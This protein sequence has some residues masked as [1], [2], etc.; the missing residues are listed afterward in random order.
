MA[1]VPADERG[2][3]TFDQGS[4]PSR[5]REVIVVG[6]RIYYPHPGEPPYRDT[7]EGLPSIQFPGMHLQYLLLPKQYFV[8]GKS[9]AN[10]EN[11][12]R[13][14]FSGIRSGTL[15]SL[16]LPSLHRKIGVRASAP[17]IQS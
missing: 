8:D 5:P 16:L 10:R 14:Y 11:A 2:I 15:L 9:Q 7:P 1:C 6:P 17:R 4:G 13:S 3:R 12:K